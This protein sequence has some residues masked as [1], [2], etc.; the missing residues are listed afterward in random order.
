MLLSL[1]PNPAVDQTVWL[2]T[3]QMDAV[4]RVRVAHLDPA[5]KGINASRMAHRLGWPTMALGF[6]AGGVGTLIESALD[7]EG[8]PHRF[9]RIDGQTRID[10]VVVENALH[11]STAIY[12]PGP[13][14][15]DAA[16]DR[17]DAV[18]DRWFN[19]AR[20]LLLA[21]SLPPGLPADYYAATI[22]RA[23]AAGLR[24]ILD[25]AGEALE[26]GIAARPHMI[27]PNIAEAEELLGRQLRDDMAVAG[28]A[29][30]LV[31]R[32][33]ETVVISMGGAGAMCAKGN[34]VWRVIPPRVEVM[35]AVGSGD[36]FVAGMAI[37]FAS[38][39]D[40]VEGLRTGAAAG[41]ATA[42]TPG[43]TLGAA[44]DVA[45]LIRAVRIEPLR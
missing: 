34:N 31:G 26:K 22:E 5:G 32:G 8:V 44:S 42:M 40:I 39:S 11:R 45:R 21:G 38:G 28:A 17:L 35:S 20:V 19:A 15:G 33:V 7:E 3:L 30:E 12:G 9:I 36:S 2:D 6:V 14:V 13:E 29:R 1:T 16:R 27:K 24:V 10:V 23:R 25:A 41:A 43:T 37:A 18:L 4:N